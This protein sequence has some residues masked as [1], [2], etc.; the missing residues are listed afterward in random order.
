MNIYISQTKLAG[1]GVE[2]PEQDVYRR[3]A[4]PI[5]HSDTT[6]QIIGEVCAGDDTSLESAICTSCEHRF[7]HK[8]PRA[9]WLQQYYR[10]KFENPNSKSP[11]EIERS[12]I[13]GPNLYKRIRSQ[14]GRLLRYGVAQEM[15]NRIFDF[16]LGLANEDGAY[17][18]KDRTIRRVLEIGC[19]NGTN[20]LYFKGRGFETFG[21]EVNP[22]RLREC[23]R[24]GLKVYSTGISNFDPVEAHAPYDFVYSAHVL[25]HVIDVDNHIRQIAA[26]IRPQGFLYI[27][28][29]DQSG[30]SLI[31]QTH[32][33]YHVHT[34][35]LAS[36]LR[37]LAKH[38][39]KAIRVAA[40]GN[41]Q[42]L[43]QKQEGVVSP[44]LS[45]RLFEDSSH[46]YLEA[47]ARHAPGEFR[48]CWD[49][50]NT[51]I[52]VL[53]VGNTVYESGL[54]PL[55]VRPGP[56]LHEIICRV[57]TSASTGPVRFI[58]EHLK[59]PPIWYKVT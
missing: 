46:P 48:V 25:E 37:L 35:S 18:T 45:G 14:V 59:V 20:L 42:V 31:Y 52:G 36:M 51:Q 57:E 4:C 30:E 54:R 26:M 49:H 3:Y 12:V 24:K 44:L 41:L 58:H 10:E 28:T 50:Y 27:E 11:D 34:F 38:G 13:R 1:H 8:F 16:L 23:Q 32:T 9:E 15:P 5:C 6:L 22:V 33:I 7:H 56:N 40:D 43:A 47:M 39:F 55:R 53:P 21:T 19:G 29:P 2:F 17:Y